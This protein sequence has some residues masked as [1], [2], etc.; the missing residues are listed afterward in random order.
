MAAS[1]VQRGALTRAQIVASALGLLER[2]GATAFSLGAVAKDL[3]VFPRAVAWHVGTREDLVVAVVDAVFEDVD[4][5]HREST[6]DAELVRVAASVR[7]TFSRH[8]AA[9]PLI[10]NRLTSPATLALVEHVTDVLA[11]GGFRGGD[12]LHA[13][14]AYLAYVIGF[15]LTES[16]GTASADEV[17][18]KSAQAHLEDVG[19]QVDVRE[20][21][22]ASF[23]AGLQM[24]LTGMRTLAP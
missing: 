22:S 3:G 16:G 13:V 5:G 21:L 19:G 24:L 2:E 17:W 11:D 18:A 15:H 12:L 14:N 6:W 9:V 23:D 10:Q 20:T 4:L 7:S 8:A 1:A